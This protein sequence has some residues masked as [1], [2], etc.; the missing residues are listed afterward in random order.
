MYTSKEM[1]K[2]LKEKGFS[3]ISDN[4]VTGEEYDEWRNERFKKEVD[5]DKDSKK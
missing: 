4:A 2:I 3:T 5:K 1:Y